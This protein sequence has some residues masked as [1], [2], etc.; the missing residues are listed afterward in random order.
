MTV[1]WLLASGVPHTDLYVSRG[2][3][4]LIDGVLVPAEV[5]ING[6]TITREQET[7]IAAPRSAELPSNG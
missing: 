5:L 1:G 7:R 4:L 2:H 6:R 3:S